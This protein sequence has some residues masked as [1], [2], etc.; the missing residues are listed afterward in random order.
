MTK[1]GNLFIVPHAHWDREWY[2]P[3]EVFN[4]RYTGMLDSLL[5]HLDSGGKYPCFMLDGQSIGA[6]DYLQARPSRE[7]SFKKHSRSGQIQTG[8]WFVS[9]DLFMSGGETLV[10]NLMWGHNTSSRWGTPLSTLYVP[11]SG[12]LISQTPQLMKGFGIEHLVFIR[13]IGNE[14]PSSEYVLQGADG[15]EVLATYLLKAYNNGG[16]LPQDTSAALRRIKDETDAIAGDTVTSWLLLNHGSDHLPPQYFLPELLE[17]IEKSGDYGK[18]KVGS[19]NDYFETIIEELNWERLPRLTGE[20]IGARTYPILPG[21]HSARMDFKIRYSRVLN[22]LIYQTEPLAAILS[23]T[24]RPVPDA[25]LSRAW[26]LILENQHHNTVGGTVIDQVHREANIRVDKVRQL[27]DE[28]WQQAG[29]FLNDRSSP[30]EDGSTKAVVL[31]PLPWKR[32]GPVH[33]KGVL[34]GGKGASIKVT[35]REGNQVPSQVLNGIKDGPRDILIQATDVPGLGARV[36]KVEADSSPDVTQELSPVIANEFF[37]VGFEPGGTFYVED[38]QGNFTIEGLNGFCDEADAGDLYNLSPIPGDITL[39][40]VLK[41]PVMEMVESGAVRRTLRLTGNLSLPAGLTQDRKKRDS[42][43]VDNPVTFLIS[44]Y[45]GLP[46]IECILSVEN[47]AED[48]RLGVTFPTS[49]K[50]DR[51]LAGQPFDM[52][53]RPVDTPSG[54]GWIETPSDR[55][56]FEGILQCGDNNG[57]LAILSNCLREYGV[58]KSPRGNELVAT[59]VRSVGWLCRHDLITRKVTVAPGLQTNGAQCREKMVFTYSLVPTGAHR[60]MSRMLKLFQQ[61][62]SPLSGMVPAPGMEPPE[63]FGGLELSPSSLVASGIIP[64]PGGGLILRL[65]N[66]TD[67]VV[68][69]RIESF[70]PLKRWRTVEMSGRGKL[71]P[72][73]MPVQITVQPRRIITLKLTPP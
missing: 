41:D 72:M 32:S 7:D 36:Y 16:F 4:V 55:Q 64:L 43:Y 56:P 46:M 28:E 53:C 40:H 63:M 51:I 12:G 68:E 34:P 29:G 60:D 45:Q 57:G 58:T 73:P 67:N 17:A 2:K 52:V 54:D 5:E 8:P 3:L 27:L 13:G 65:Y 24:G 50:E 44:L 31:N 49:C 62:R 18:L 1:P 70:C 22:R 61:C 10:R 71:K 6:L 25:L 59:L 38:L 69:G 11:E 14:V 19:Y 35:D 26:E 48:H 39:T 30:S 20:L 21:R 15:T 47:R 66:P 33:I 23:M 37:R 9:P 42:R